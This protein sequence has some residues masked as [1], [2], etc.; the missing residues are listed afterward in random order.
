MY[1]LRALSALHARE[2]RALS[3]LHAREARALS[4]LYSREA[5]SAKRIQTRSVEKLF[6]EQ[7]FDFMSLAILFRC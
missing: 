3:A 1:E 2:A 4:A 7:I 6:T 5:L